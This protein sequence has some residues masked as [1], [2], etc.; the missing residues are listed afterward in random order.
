MSDKINK[1]NL[2]QKYL[3]ENLTIN[4]CAIFFHKSKRTII[5]NLNKFDLKKIPEGG[6]YHELR[7]K[8]WLKQ[9]YIIE[10]KSSIKIAEILGCSYSTVLTWLR[11][12]QLPLRKT[13]ELK[14]G[15]PMSEEQKNKLSNSKKG[16][17]TGE[18]NPNWKGGQISDYQRARNSRVSRIW[19]KKV[20]ER[21]N[22]K[23][24]FPNCIETKN[25][26][27]HHIKSYL[28][29][30]ELR[31]ELNNGITLCSKHHEE[32]HSFEFPYWIKKKQKKYPSLIIKV[33]PNNRLKKFKPPIKQIKRLY[34]NDALS[35]HK[36]GLFYGVAPETVRKKLIELGI[37]RRKSGGKKKFIFNKKELFKLY[38][39]MPMSKI[40]LKLGCG[41]TL[42]HK[43]IH[44]FKI[45]IINKQRR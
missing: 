30:P 16:K 31:Y 22:F 10:K 35:T 12:H 43:H 33:G 29:Y 44:A 7:D 5:R 11:K 40:A 37:K 8:K 32:L 28:E 26:H 15:V 38:Q 4:E 18:N 14:K 36:I 45:P 23:C 17:Y 2:K 42:I 39:S 24:Q 34:T 27:A 21:D 9:K 1:I 3:V 19:S 20:R 25:L 41:E 13:G 6:M